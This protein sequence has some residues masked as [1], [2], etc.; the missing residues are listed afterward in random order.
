MNSIW[1]RV[2]VA[3]FLVAMLGCANTSKSAQPGPAPESL[4]VAIVVTN[5]SFLYRRIELRIDNAVVL[6]TI[7][8]MPST[9]HAQA[10]TDTI[11]VAAGEHEVTLLDHH[12]NRRFSAI[13]NTRPGEMTILIRLLRS[14]S[15]V[16]TVYGELG[17]R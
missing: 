2:G 13:L 17:L 12:T 10:L 8:G 7:V 5:E 4:P 11:R 9:I 16:S 14:H 3:A 6:D 15:G 1:N